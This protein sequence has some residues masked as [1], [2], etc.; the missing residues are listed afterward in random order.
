MG[1]RKFW[2]ENLPRLKYHN[3]AVPMIV[4]RTRDQDGPATLS[5][6]MVDD[7]KGSAPATPLLDIPDAKEAK[8]DVEG[9]GPTSGGKDES[10]IQ[11][12][13]AALATVDPW[14]H[15]A[16][17]TDGSAR[18]PPPGKGER[19]VTINVK[20][21]FS[22]DILK[23]FLERTGATPVEATAEDEAELE[24]IAKLA[25]QA[26]TDRQVQKTYRD[27]IKA[28]KAMLERARKEADALKAAD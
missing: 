4:N 15:I 13:Q 9:T 8:E 17:S 25:E 18:A 12:P 1:P 5:I 28:E 23:Q 26:V 19:V 20:N 10:V 27:K 21:T 11:P 6:Y 22:E 2:R 3:P 7:G 14:E 16:S 24:T